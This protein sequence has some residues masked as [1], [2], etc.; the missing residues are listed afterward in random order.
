MEIYNEV[1]RDLLDNYA[2]D[3]TQSAN[4][5]NN[6]NSIGRPQSSPSLQTTTATNNNSRDTTPASTQGPGLKIME[7]PEQVTDTSIHMYIT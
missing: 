7:D 4:N 6:N 2:K 3:Q 5:N 1:V